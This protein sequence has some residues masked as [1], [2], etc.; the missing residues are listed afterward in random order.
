MQGA[1][2]TPKRTDTGDFTKLPVTG[3][4][5]CCGWAPTRA[6]PEPHST[7]F[8]V[9]EKGDLEGS[10]TSNNQALLTIYQKRTQELYMIQLV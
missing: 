1:I 8:P 6:S 10:V 9:C 2:K 7:W 5:S 4:P 3:R